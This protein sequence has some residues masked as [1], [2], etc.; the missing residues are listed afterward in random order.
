M[1]N[2]Y[3]YPLFAYVSSLNP[4]EGRV[5]FLEFFSPTFFPSFLNTLYFERKFF[6]RILWRMLLSFRRKTTTL[7]RQVPHAQSHL[8]GRKKG[9]TEVSGFPYANLYVNAGLIH[10][11]LTNINHLSLR[12]WFDGIFK[13]FSF[14]KAVAPFPNGW[15]TQLI[16]LRHN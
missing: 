8:V 7:R 9:R 2:L 15:V 1:A 11:L 14:F 13:T 12:H 5:W 4:D 10:A 3:M 6:F 16:L